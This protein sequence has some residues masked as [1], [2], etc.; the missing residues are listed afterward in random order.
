MTRKA[1]YTI[2]MHVLLFPSL[3][4]SPQEKLEARLDEILLQ[5]EF[6]AQSFEETRLETI[7]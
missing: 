7:R 4:M 2:L 6:D 3:F 1:G 5:D